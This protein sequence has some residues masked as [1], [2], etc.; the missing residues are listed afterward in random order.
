[1]F[2]I[3]RA[4][5]TVA[6]RAPRAWAAATPQMRWFADEAEEPV[7]RDQLHYDV[8]CVG[9]GPA[10][11]SAAIRIKQLALEREQE[12]SVC[13]VEKGGELGAHILSGNVFETRGL[14]ELF[15]DWREMGEEGP[16]IE[17]EVKEDAFLFLSETQSLQIPNFVL[18][19]QLHNEGNYII[20]LT[21]LV[22]WLGEQAEELGVEIYPGFSASEVVYNE[23]GSAVLGVATRDVGIDKQGQMKGTY[24]PGIELRARQTLFSE[25]C[26]GSLSEE[27][28]ETFDLRAEAD[29]QTY[30]LGIKEVWEVPAEN[31][32]PGFVQHTLG[33]PLQ[34][35]PLDT[36]FGGSFLYHMN[37]QG[38]NLI[39][40]GFVVGLDY[41]NPYLS[42]YRE[43]Q[44]WKHHPAV[45]KH[46]EGGE[47][48][49][50][51]A[52]ALNEGGYHAIPEL[53]FPGG[54]LLGC[55]AG[56]LNSVKIKGSHTAIKSGM[57]AGEAVFE[58]LTKDDQA[59]KSVYN[60]EMIDYEE[61]LHAPMQATKYQEDMNT[62]WVSQELKEVRNC[63]GAFHYGLIPGLAYAAASA[64]LLKGKESWTFHNT[65]SDAEKTR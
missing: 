51:G 8:V 55:S 35:G 30:G 53:T 10:G 26:R 12:L 7:E 56:F 42:P 60:M 62:N 15:P 21:Q 25:G 38:Q 5:T 57:T 44:R 18:P 48:I 33:W 17:T 3:N 39:L 22:K 54:A 59:E 49:S 43:F 9:G 4:A 50:Y 27:L 40:V 29:V 11:L 16:P 20:S 13:V 63:H 46:L 36:T 34:S 37:S 24:E 31:H 58:L 2:A 52:R 65:K 28:M 19:P 1:M 45:M 23:D 64:W 6:R 61:E 32:K 14:D 41:E 47:C